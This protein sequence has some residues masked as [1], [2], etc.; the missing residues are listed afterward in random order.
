[1]LKSL[2]VIAALSVVS[3]FISSAH[4][5]VVVTDDIGVS[6]RLAQPARRIVSLAP[7]ITETLF[8]AGAGKQIVGTVEFSDYPEAA[9]KITRI[10]GYS[11][12]DLEV[13]AALKP[14]L[15]V[16]WE[17]GN[18]K[19]QVEK[20]RAMGF[21]VYTT[22][23][24]SLE[25]IASTL[26][27]LSQLAGTTDVGRKAATGMR[28]QLERLRSRYASRPKV[29]TFYQ[30][31]KQPLM[32]VGGQQI[33]SNVIRLCGGDNVF[34]NLDQMAASVTVESV[35]A[36]NPEAIVA[37]GM[38]DSR[39][40]WLDDWRRWASITAVARDNLFYIPPDLVQRHTPRL[41]EGAERLC[42]QLE[43]ARSRRPRG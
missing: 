10:G 27:R 11:R 31:W 40:E 37:S 3:G 29:R 30:I 20:L 1:M 39:P 19:A 24:N 12:L 26:E 16:A 21:A 43:T 4:A 33:I 9:K 8:A 14:D 22:Q 17:S 18:I 36:A 7:H 41:L 6:I 38:G 34:A 2:T 28:E 13:I 15:V 23:P 35:I 42:Q 5:E 32:T 25:D